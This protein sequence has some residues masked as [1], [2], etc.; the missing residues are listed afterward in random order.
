MP[1]DLSLRKTI[2]GG[3]TTPHDYLVIWDGLPVGRIFSTHAVGGGE[4]WSWSCFLP[5]VPQRSHH[6][7]RATRL[8][9]AKVE[10][11]K[12]WTELQG[13]ISHDQIRAARAMTSDHSRPWHPRG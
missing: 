3:E 9:H 10:F 2:I 8:A 13:E 1:D 12:A 4:E 11:R 5:N 6:R 7:G